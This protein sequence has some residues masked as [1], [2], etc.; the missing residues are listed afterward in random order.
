MDLRVSVMH[1]IQHQILVAATAA[2]V[3]TGAPVR[4]QSIHGKLIAE[5]TD[6]PVAAASVRL[7]TDQ[8]ARIGEGTKSDANGVFELKAPAEG[9]YRLRAERSGFQTAVSP[10]M[11][12]RPREEVGIEFHLLPDTLLLR[13]VVVTA[14][15]RQAPG[16]LGGFYERQASDGFGTFITRDRIDRERPFEVT[17]LLRTVPGLNVLPARRGFGS[18]VRTTEGCTPALYLN[19]LRFPMMGETIDQIVSPNDVEAVEVYAHAGEVPV[20]FQSPRSRCGAV[21]VWTRPAL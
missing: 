17:D 15:S 20:E 8:G 5:G 13:P 7:V 12:L 14:H 2:V 9:V 4:A 21:V 6:R 16:K 10:A 3:L 18:A 11:E 1:T 19:G